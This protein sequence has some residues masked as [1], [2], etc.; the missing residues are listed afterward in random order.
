[1]RFNLLNILGVKKICFTLLIL[2]NSK[3]LELN[4]FI[5]TVK[6]AE[7]YNFVGCGF[8]AKS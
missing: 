8:D 6:I 1:M 5:F 4:L 7:V 2:N 3:S